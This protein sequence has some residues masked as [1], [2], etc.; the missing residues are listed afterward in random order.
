MTE[1][2]TARPDLSQARSRPRPAAVEADP[3]DPAGAAPQPAAQ[4]TKAPDPQ[5]PAGGT[6]RLAPI[7]S[8]EATIA[9]Q[10]RLTDS[11][12][13]VLLRVQEIRGDRRGIDTMRWILAT[14][15]ARFIADATADAKTN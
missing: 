3:A 14:Y 9:V 10:Y 7:S 1:H 13:D 2:S 4:A 12:R 15:G 5:R 8:A 6:R 11:E